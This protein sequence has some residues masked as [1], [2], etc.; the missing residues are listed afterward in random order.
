MTVKSI[1]CRLDARQLYTLRDIAQDLYGLFKGYLCVVSDNCGWTIMMS[2]NECHKVW[3][4][5]EDHGDV[6]VTFFHETDE[7]WIDLVRK[8]ELLVGPVQDRLALDVTW[9][10]LPPVPKR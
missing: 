3:T 8:L 9:T 7:V 2:A 5:K 6:V 1:I 10:K 4:E